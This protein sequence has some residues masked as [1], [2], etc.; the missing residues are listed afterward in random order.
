MANVNP[1]PALKMPRIILEDREW[2]D[3]ERDR[4]TIL[5]QLW[6]RTGGN[7]DEVEESKN[8]ITSSSS[9]V[10]RNAA[11]INSLELRQFEIVNT[12]S[13]LTT[14]D[15]QVVICKNT[16][17]ISITLDPQAV[18]DDEV[19]IKRRGV[20]IEVIGSIDGF[21]NKTINLLNYSMH[22]IFDGTDWSEI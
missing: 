8:N 15:Y 11:R 7:T 1:P 17:P 5:F 19:H 14:R 18:E 9:R 20:S 2:R 12:I 10:S 4:D 3:Y 13:D 22:L 21:T 6:Q 16:V